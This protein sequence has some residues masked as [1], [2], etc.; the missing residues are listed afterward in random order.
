MWEAVFEERHSSYTNVFTLA[1]TEEEARADLKL[2][3]LAKSSRGLG[4]YDESAL[5]RPA[6]IIGPDEIHLET[7]Y[8]G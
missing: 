7:H 1:E 2:A 3:F 6:T 4:K 8:L 5:D